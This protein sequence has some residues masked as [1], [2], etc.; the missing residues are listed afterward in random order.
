MKNILKYAFVVLSFYSLPSLAQVDLQE[1]MKSGE[2]EPIN[3]DAD[4]LIIKNNE[5]LAI[6]KTNVH[7]VQGKMDLRADEVRMFTEYNEKTKKSVLKKLEAQYNVDFNAPGKSVQS[8][9]AEYDVIGGI[10]ELKGNVRM[11]DADTSLAGKYFKYNMKT[12]SSEIKNSTVANTGG[13]A[14]VGTEAQPA[15]RVRA[16]FTPGK[17]IEKFSTP[18]DKI[19]NVRGAP[20]PVLDSEKMQGKDPNENIKYQNPAVKQLE[21]K[22]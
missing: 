12:G 2:G 14:A 13:A 11:K 8:D 16:V 5:N 6:F 7:V 21:N 18:L 3:I 17:D 1:V 19:Q 20:V 10:L 22:Q 9:L 15:G 4:N